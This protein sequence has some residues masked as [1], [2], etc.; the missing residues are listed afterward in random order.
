MGL[1]ARAFLDWKAFGLQ[2][3]PPPVQERREGGGEG[4]VWP[5]LAGKPEQGPQ[6]VQ[7]LPKAPCCWCELARGC[8]L[9]PGV[10]K[11]GR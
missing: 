9:S 8:G 3:G 7:C 6:I 10:Q 1:T 2:K 11:A 5:D 4:L